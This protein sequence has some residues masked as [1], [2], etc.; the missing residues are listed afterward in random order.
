MDFVCGYRGRMSTRLYLDFCGEDHTLNLGDTLT[1]G[2]SSELVIHE[3]PYMHRVVG[4][5]VARDGVWCV[6]N[7]GRR[8]VLTV[9]DES[10]PSI[11][12][13]AP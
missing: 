5:F 2:R 1:S 10:G 3:N 13:V 8:I 7:L 4:R 12:T 6:E 11:A 9:R